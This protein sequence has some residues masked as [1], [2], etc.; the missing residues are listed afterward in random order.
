MAYK[1]ILTMTAAPAGRV[2]DG[3]PAVRGLMMRNYAALG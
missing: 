1:S 3:A 2:S